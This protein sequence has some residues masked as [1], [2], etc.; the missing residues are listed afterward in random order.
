MKILLCGKSVK[1][2]DH[3]TATPEAEGS[4]P[5]CPE[6]C[7]RASKKDRKFFDR[8]EFPVFLLPEEDG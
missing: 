2:V 5:F 4:S 8:K 7:F 3:L 6:I 1:K